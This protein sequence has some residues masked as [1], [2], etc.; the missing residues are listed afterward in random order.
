MIIITIIIALTVKAKPSNL[1]HSSPDPPRKQERQQQ[2]KTKENRTKA[3]RAPLERI[4]NPFKASQVG[5]R[6]ETRLQPRQL[7]SLGKATRVY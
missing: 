6:S 1:P 7:L 3:D 4:P 2:K 5:E